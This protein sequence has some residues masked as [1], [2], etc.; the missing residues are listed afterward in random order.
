MLLGLTACGQPLV[1]PRPLPSRLAADDVRRNFVG[2]WRLEF[3]VD[4]VVGPPSSEAGRRWIAPPTTRPAEGVLDVRDSL[5]E[6]RRQVLAAALELDFRG[7]LG[8]SMSCLDGIRGFTVTE[9][10]GWAWLGF[11]PE[12]F[13]CGLVARVAEADFRFV[14][15]TVHGQWHER[16]I[17]GPVA[18]GTFRMYR[19]SAPGARLPN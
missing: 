1:T 4:S 15:D 19:T 10:G 14:G 2:H 7:V 6:P 12:I 8:R 9:S 11:M 3:R 16:S 18:R 5:V 13:D 17:R